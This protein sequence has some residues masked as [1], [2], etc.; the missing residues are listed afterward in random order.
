MWNMKKQKD[1]Q[2]V[3]TRMILIKKLGP[4]RC[5]MSFNSV[6]YNQSVFCEVTMSPSVF[7]HWILFINVNVLVI[8]WIHPYYMRIPAEPN[9]ETV[10]ES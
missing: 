6:I 3:N 7:S 9:N 4:E 5:K 8:E 10:F 2:V 1:H